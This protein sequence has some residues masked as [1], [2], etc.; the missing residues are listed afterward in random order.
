MEIYGL[1]STGNRKTTICGHSTC[2]SL[3][4]L[5]LRKF[6]GDP[7]LWSHWSFL[8]KSIVQDANLSMNGKMKHLQNSV[9]GKAKSAIEIKQIAESERAPSIMVIEESTVMPMERALGV[10]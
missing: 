7:L 5:R 3:P 10:I 8:L 2:E 9:I 6:D 4:K 1:E